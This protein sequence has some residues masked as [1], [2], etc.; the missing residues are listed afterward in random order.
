[1]ENTSAELVKFHL[2]LHMA[3]KTG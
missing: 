3:M 1:M 2:F